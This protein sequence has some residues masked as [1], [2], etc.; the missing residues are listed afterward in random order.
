MPAVYLTPS[1]R[2]DLLD[3]YRRAANPGVRLRAHILLLL[4]AGHPWATISAVLFCSVSTVSRWKRRFE[5]EGV[6]AVLGRPRGRQRSGIHVWAALVVRW[7][8]TAAPADFRFT[9][10]RWSCEAVGRL[11][12]TPRHTLREA[13]ASQQ[14]LEVA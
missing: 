3:Y 8:L 14:A 12:A 5:A 13:Q 1:E 6:D 7:V 10:S 4:D 2:H 9:R 11:D